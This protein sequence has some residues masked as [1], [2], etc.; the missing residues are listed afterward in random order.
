MRVEREALRLHVQH[1]SNEDRS[2][3]L[4]QSWSSFQYWLDLVI[5]RGTVVTIDGVKI[6]YVAI[7]RSTSRG[8]VL[9]PDPAR[10]L[11]SL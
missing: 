11:T 8:E 10:S 1:A 3:R 5:G 4:R 6:G 9:V 2:R 7:Q